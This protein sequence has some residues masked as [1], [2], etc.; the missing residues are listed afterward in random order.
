MSRLP[1]EIIWKDVSSIDEFLVD[2]LNK[3]LYQV[4]Q[5]VKNA[6]FR[7]TIP[8]VELFN[9]LYYLCIS[10]IVDN[11]CYHELENEI[12]AR[13]G[14]A[15]TSDLLIS[16][17]YSVFYLQ[18]KRPALFE[19]FEKYVNEY[20]RNKGWYFDFFVNFLNNH[21]ARYH[22]DFTPRPEDA[23]VLIQ[24][25][26]NWLKLTDRFCPLD[27]KSILLF[28]PHQEDR[29]MILQ[30]IETSFRKLSDNKDTL[31][32]VE[33][34]DGISTYSFRAD[35]VFPELRELMSASKVEDTPSFQ[36][37]EVDTTIYPFVVNGKYAKIIIDKIKALTTG[38]TSPRDK[39][40]PIRAAIDAGVIR[41]PSYTEIVKALGKDFIA[42]S[43][44]HN[45]TNPGLQPFQ[46][47]P[48]FSQLVSEFKKIIE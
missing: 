48:S 18:D 37:G 40:M 24:K 13:F 8:D 35:N 15:Y 16:M 43:S 17:I 10:L 28:W 23:K 3:E 22:T 34:R 5:K 11:V 21:R 14:R 27:I 12:Y 31:M 42:N 44:Y 47:N 1:R 38:K 29:L 19:S 30:A 2:P 41:R 46:A 33:K 4:Y 6:P 45:Y 32:F 36:I 39:M 26:I 9:E 7:I 25:N 20:Q